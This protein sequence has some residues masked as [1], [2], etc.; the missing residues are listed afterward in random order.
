M[1]REERKQREAL[2]A[3]YGFE[4]DVVQEDGTVVIKNDK[5][6]GGTSGIAGTV[7]SFRSLLLSV[8]RRGAKS[9]AYIGVLKAVT[10]NMNSKV[11]AMK[12]QE[13]RE[14]SK[15]AHQEKVRRDKELLERQQA[16]KDKEKKRTQKREKRRGC[17]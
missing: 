15:Q 10:E 2:L 16:A 13:K 1:S 14:K 8:S 17:G 12:E 4:T 5:S 9:D 6:K 3:T 7:L 11:V